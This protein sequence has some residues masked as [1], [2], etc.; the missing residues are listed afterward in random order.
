MKDGTETDPMKGMARSLYRSKIVAWFNSKFK[1]PV[2]QIPCDELKKL[3]A[4]VNVNVN[5]GGERT[6]SGFNV[7]KPSGNEIFDGR[8][9]STLEGIVSSGAELP[10]PPPNYPELLNPTLSFSF[11]TT[12]CK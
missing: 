4:A 8:V 1:P 5:V 9:R 12:N 3:S 11:H 7:L 6:V 2:D 10:P